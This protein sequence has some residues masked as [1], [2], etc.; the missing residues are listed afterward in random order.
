MPEM[1][2]LLIGLVQ[3][4]FLLLVAPFFTGLSRVLRAKVHSRKG[5]SILQDYRDIFKLIKRQEVVP[6]QSSWVFRITPYVIMA[7]MLLIAM[8]I[9]VLTLQA[10]LGMV[11]DL[12]VIVYLFT[13]FRFFFSIAGLDSGSSFAGI[14]ASR[15]MALGVL[16]EPTI[17]LV[18]FVVALLSGSTDLGIISQKMA[19]G[20]I[21]YLSPAVLL[22][23][24]AFAVATFIE[25][26]KIPFDLA[27]AEAEIQEG[28][29]TEYSGRS[30]AILK[31]SLGLKQMVVNALYLAIFFPF[32]NAAVVTPSAILVSM[33]L[34]LLKVVVIY[35]V[36]ALLENSMARFVLFKTPA[37]TWIVFGIAMLSYVFYMVNI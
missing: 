9:P 26:G 7:T 3:A 24:V 13:V 10:P 27:E 28:P 21:S 22:G 23:M 4:V 34:F 32:G 25:S 1:K 33:V 16:V 20:E 37:V 5:P 29:L 18:L 11:G 2:L 19:T 31:W 35:V 30:L 15:E 6:A 12:I 8:I 14:G 36:A 17:I